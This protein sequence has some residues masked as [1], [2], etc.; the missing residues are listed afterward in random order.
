MSFEKVQYS[1]TVSTFRAVTYDALGVFLVV[2]LS[3]MSADEMGETFAE[4][5][6]DSL[7][8]SLSMRR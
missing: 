6:F 3:D 2:E 1:T 4:D 7:W 5:L 8:A